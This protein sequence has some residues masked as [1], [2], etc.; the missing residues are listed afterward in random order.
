MRNV[1]GFFIIVL[2][3]FAY[4]IPVHGAVVPSL[5]IR[6]YRNGE[7]FPYV[8]VELYLNGTLLTHVGT[9][10]ENG[11]V[12]FSNVETGN[13][14]IQVVNGS[15]VWIFIVIIDENTSEITLNIE[16]SNDG[17]LTSIV[18]FMGSNKHV[19]YTGIAVFFIV[20]L[21]IAFAFSGR[22][23]PRRR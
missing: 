20:I 14:T 15:S 17:I 4:A 13:Y 19:L 1:Y 5:T 21:L 12:V 3:I 7:P 2:I 23:I 9:T 18:E 10:D 8:D 22:K 11:T 6:V 16:E